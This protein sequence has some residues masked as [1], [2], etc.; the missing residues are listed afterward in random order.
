MHRADRQS[1]ERNRCPVMRQ[2]ARGAMMWR[3]ALNSKRTNREWR[4]SRTAGTPGRIVPASRRQM[5][6][7]ACRPVRIARRIRL[8]GHARRNIDVT[9]RAVRV[10]VNAI[11]GRMPRGA[12]D[13]APMFDPL[14]PDTAQGARSGASVA[15][16]RRRF[17]TWRHIDRLSGHQKPASIDRA[18]RS[19]FVLILRASAVFS[20]GPPSAHAT[21]PPPCGTGRRLSRIQVGVGT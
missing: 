6:P 10:L 1:N 15:P 11:N 12:I 13:V 20:N 14:L 17:A 18:M 3:S 5:Q 8:S 9:I 19:D 7:V 2:S 4:S 21:A 16:A